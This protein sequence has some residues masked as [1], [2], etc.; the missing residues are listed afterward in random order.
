MKKNSVSKFLGTAKVAMSKRSPEILTGLGIA[1]MVTTTV[2]AVRATPK[3]LELIEQKKKELCEDVITPTDV[4]KTAWKPYVPAAVTGAVSI[5]CLVGASSVNARRNAALYSAYKLSETALSE[6]KEKVVETIGEKKE[7]VVREK[8]AK[9]KVDNNPPT[10]NNIIIC[11]GETLFYDP[12]SGRY[13]ESSKDKIEKT[14][15]ELNKQML[16]GMFGYITLNEFYDEIGLPQ[17]S[18]GDDLGWNI[19]HGMID[20]TLTDAKVSEDGKPAIVL[21]YHVAPRYDYNKY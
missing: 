9:D 16:Q 20:V 10:G 18:L 6:Y 1:G 13:F 11:G 15:N 19:D 21:D 2:L 3:A 8:I 12:I 14:E 7:Q 17:V 4:V 5:A